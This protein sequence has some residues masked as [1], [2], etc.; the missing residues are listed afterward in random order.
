M[1]EMEDGEMGEEQEEEEVGDRTEEEME[2]TLDGNTRHLDDHFCQVIHQGMTLLQS[3]FI[4]AQRWE[5][6][7][8]IQHPVGHL[9]EH[10]FP[11][12]LPGTG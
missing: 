8:L 10:I 1:V 9:P 5:G 12:Q 2:D 11:L 6:I 7:T 3:D 4:R